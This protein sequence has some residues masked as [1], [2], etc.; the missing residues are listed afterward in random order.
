MLVNNMCKYCD[1]NSKDCEI[2][3]EPLTSEWYL[4]I[5]TH[6]WDK[7]DDVYVHQKL[8]GVAYCPYC[9]RKLSR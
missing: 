3:Q 7:Y 9:G 2:F 4:D 1:Y 5:E 8:Y 6:E